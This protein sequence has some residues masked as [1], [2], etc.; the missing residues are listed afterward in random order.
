[1]VLVGAL[2][3]CLSLHHRMPPS[4]TQSPPPRQPSQRSLFALLMQRGPP[5][6]MISIIVLIM[7]ELNPKPPNSKRRLGSSSAS[8]LAFDRSRRQLLIRSSLAKG[9]LRTGGPTAHRPL[10]ILQ[11]KALLIRLLFIP[12]RN[13]RI[14]L[15]HL[16]QQSA[17]SSTSYRHVPHHRV[18]VEKVLEKRNKWK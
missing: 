14:F 12:R 17:T 1:M 7:M 11:R 4:E 10:L 18:R 8:P 9:T 5:I 3:P 2:S 15:T 13:L 16:A 6:I